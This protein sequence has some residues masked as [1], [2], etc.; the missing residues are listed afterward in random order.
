MYQ[1]TKGLNDASSTGDPRLAMTHLQDLEQILNFPPAQIKLNPTL[2]YFCTES[3]RSFI[4]QWQELVKR[5]A[6]YPQVRYMA[7]LS[8]RSALR[9]GSADA[10]SR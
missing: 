1:L 5:F 4:L 3:F 10:Q 2:H 9:F 8:L 6:D 7:S